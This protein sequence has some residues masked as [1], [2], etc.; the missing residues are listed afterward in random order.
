[1][2]LGEQVRGFGFGHD[3]SFDTTVT[4]GFAPAFGRGLADPAEPLSSFPPL[5]GIQ[6]NNPA[7]L[8]HLPAGMAIHEALDDYMMVFESNFAPIVGQ[9][10]TLTGANAAAAEARIDL[11]LARA[12][13]DECQL[14]AVLADKRGSEGLLYSGGVFLRDSA[15]KSALSD[16]ALRAKAD[17]KTSVTYTCVPKGNGRRIALDRDLDGVLDGDE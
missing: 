8:S 11:L 7:G 6:V 15:G 3:G 4:F 5:F 12:G 9:Q 1:M 2:F 10:V 17:S 16:A 13:H 14:V